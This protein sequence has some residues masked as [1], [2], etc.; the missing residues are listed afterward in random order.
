MARRD[1]E[2]DPLDGT[3]QYITERPALEDEADEVAYATDPEP[4]GE[5]TAENVPLA[6]DGSS[7][8]QFPGCAAATDR[9]Y[10][11]DCRAAMRGGGE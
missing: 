8:C 3:A 4:E 6:G 11:S 9:T 10:C 1:Y 5:E 7:G 2:G